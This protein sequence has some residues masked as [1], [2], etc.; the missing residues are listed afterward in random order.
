[1]LVYLSD[2][3]PDS[4]ARNPTH[5]FLTRNHRLVKCPLIFISDTFLKFLSFLV[6]L[7][8]F[9]LFH[10]GFFLS[11][12][13]LLSNEVVFIIFLFDSQIFATLAVPLVKSVQS[14][15]LSELLNVAFEI[16]ASLR[17]GLIQG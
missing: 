11:F 3:T 12:K 8:E 5:T 7:N 4:C 10:F 15:V 13:L 2:V 6:V 17:L 9:F 1:M 14:L 16:E